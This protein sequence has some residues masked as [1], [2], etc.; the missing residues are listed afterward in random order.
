M[1]FNFGR[2]LSKI[3]NI[4]QFFYS[5]KF[6]FI[7]AIIEETRPCVEAN[8][9]SIARKDNQNIEIFR[10]LSNKSEKFNHKSS[11]QR[12]KKSSSSS[13]TPTLNSNQ[14]YSRSNSAR[15]KITT[16]KSATI[17]ISMVVLFLLTHFYRVTLKIYEISTPKN[18]MKDFTF[19]LSKNR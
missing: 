4:H 6:T 12:A 8:E 11:H 10:Q 5:Y 17:L 13:F 16:Y 15:L 9:L 3:I 14:H 19:C 18:N 1:V 2:V 7:Q